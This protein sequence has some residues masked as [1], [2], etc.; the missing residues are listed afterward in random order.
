MR[1]S[2]YGRAMHFYMW[3]GRFFAKAIMILILVL[4]VSTILIVAVPEFSLHKV[5]F[6]ISPYL[7]VAIAQTR[8]GIAFLVSLAGGVILAALIIP[9]AFLEIATEIRLKKRVYGLVQARRKMSLDE[10]VRETGVLESDLS[11]LLKNWIMK[12]GFDSYRIANAAGT[13]KRGHLQ[14]DLGARELSWQE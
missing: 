8:V 9:P 4:L 3:F 11:F 7:P 12:P 5:G 10:L 6:T 13:I 1:L 2:F 14:I